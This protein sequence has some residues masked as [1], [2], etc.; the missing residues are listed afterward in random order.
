MRAR[1]R[2]GEQGMAL[3]TVLLL[4]A[5]MSVLAVSVLDDIRFGVRRT[6]NATE[7]GQAQ[8]YAIGAEELAQL[9]IRRL[10]AQNPLRTTAIGDWNGREFSFPIEGGLIRARLEDGSDCF[11]LNSVVAGG[12]ENWTADPDGVSQFRA[13]LAALQVP[14]LEAELVSAALVDWIDS[15][16]LDDAD[17]A[18]AAV[19]RRTG[20]ALL[21]E[22]SELRAIE[23]VSPELY[24]RLRPFVCALP[25]EF[26]SARLSPI[27]VNTLRQDQA[28]LI[29]AITNGVLSPAE[30]QAW[31]AGRPREGWTD[32]AA[33]FSHPRL[34]D[35]PPPPSAR[36]QVNDGLRTQFFN[37]RAVVVVGQA[38][39]AMNSLFEQD[40]T[41]AVRLVARRWTEGD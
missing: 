15:D 35:N 16:T 19:P 41:G 24:A 8:W 30:A 33:F 4:V 18:R 10:H 31:L 38:E 11:D 12:R 28:L 34:V 32:Q 7:V 1:I 3:L 2:N 25:R 22:V 40:D 9:Q 23:G 26:P 13:L 5:V 14:A 21:E 27:N 20:A 37:L 6:A 17:Y 36:L 29:T 39:V